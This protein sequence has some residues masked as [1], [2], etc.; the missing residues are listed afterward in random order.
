ML[1]YP[2]ASAEL[3]QCIMSAWYYAGSNEFLRRCSAV[4]VIAVKHESVSL[5]A[6]ICTCTVFSLVLLGQDMTGH[7]LRGSVD[8]IAIGDSSC[9]EVRLG[10]PSA[11]EGRR[12]HAR[13]GTCLA[14]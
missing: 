1:R 6:A 14:V 2:A 10:V 9:G 3:R 8:R 13:A 5:L 11:R 4:P 7:D 12:G